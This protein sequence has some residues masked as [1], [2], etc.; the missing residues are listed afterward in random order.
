M[1]NSGTNPASMASEFVDHRGRAEQ[2]GR[3]VIRTES[4]IL[5]GEGPSQWAGDAAESIGIIVKLDELEQEILSRLATGEA[6]VSRLVTMRWF[7]YEADGDS[8]VVGPEMQ[9]RFEDIAGAQ[10][11]EFTPVDYPADRTL[12]FRAGDLPLVREAIVAHGIPVAPSR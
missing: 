7:T 11:V 1:D 5:A 8:Y 2:G 4:R 10:L 12:G 9:R 6:V 3:L